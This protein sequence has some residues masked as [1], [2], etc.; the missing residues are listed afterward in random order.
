MPG[1]ENMLKRMP[2]IMPERI[3]AKKNA[4]KCARKYVR[5]DTK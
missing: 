4:K 5:I 1:P 2:G 3:Y